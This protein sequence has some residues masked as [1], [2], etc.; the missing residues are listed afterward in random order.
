MELKSIQKKEEDDNK[1]S[2]EVSWGTKDEYEEALKDPICMKIYEY[3]KDNKENNL[4]VLE[5]EIRQLA[6][7]DIDKINKAYIISQMLLSEKTHVS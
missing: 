3:I 5:K 1:F 6:N 7:N 2:Y 4:V